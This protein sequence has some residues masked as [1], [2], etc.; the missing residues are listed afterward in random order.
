[1]SGSPE[2][3]FAQWVAD[4]PDVHDRAR[5]QDLLDKACSLAEE[6]RDWRRKEKG[7]VLALRARCPGFDDGIY[8]AALGY[9]Y[10]VT[11]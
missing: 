3:G 1:M 5:R 6:V 9:G 11:R 4:A 7:A 8:E 2:Q 10:F